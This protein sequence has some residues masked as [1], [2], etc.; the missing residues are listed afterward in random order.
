MGI[1]CDDDKTRLKRGDRELNDGAT[2]SECG[3]GDAQLELVF[4]K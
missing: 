4:L 3:L 1:A 2:M